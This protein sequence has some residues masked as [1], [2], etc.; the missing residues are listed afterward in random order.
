MLRRYI[1][2]YEIEVVREARE[3]LAVKHEG[4]EPIAK[5]FLLIGLWCPTLLQYVEK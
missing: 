3:V 1:I 4:V 2:E 5:F